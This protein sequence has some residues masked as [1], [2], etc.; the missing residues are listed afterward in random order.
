MKTALLLSVLCGH[1][2]I[3]FY[4]TDCHKP[5]GLADGRINDTQITAGS[6]Y[7]NNKILYGSSRARLN[8]SGGY[9]AN[10]R[11]SASAFLSVHFQQ[12]MII[13]GIATQG[14]LGENIQEW[15]KVYLLGYT[16]G[17]G[18]VYFFKERYQN[19]AKVIW[20]QSSN[21]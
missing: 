19:A 16:F 13:T 7:Q 15:T 10:P 18:K 11:S 21:L 8:Q 4:P 12:A 9:R 20:E 2:C 14:Y 1:V 17:S 5:L 3:C 6:V